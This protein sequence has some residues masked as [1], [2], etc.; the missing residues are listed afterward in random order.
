MI[1]L[2]SFSSFSLHTHKGYYVLHYQIYVNI[3]KK[4]IV[5]FFYYLFFL[6]AIRGKGFPS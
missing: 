6:I 2:L 3:L 4:K 1:F 5:G